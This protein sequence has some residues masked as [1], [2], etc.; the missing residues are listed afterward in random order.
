[1]GTKSVIIPAEEQSAG[2]VVG[3]FYRVEFH[4][5]RRFFSD[6]NYLFSLQRFKNRFRNI[7]DAC[8]HIQQLEKAKAFLLDYTQMRMPLF[9]PN[10]SEL[11]CFQPFPPF[12]SYGVVEG[13]HSTDSND[14]VK[15]RSGFFIH[16]IFDCDPPF[17]PRV[18][19]CRD[20]FKN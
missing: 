11:V 8:D 16:L 20:A 13:S 19:E 2:C 4:S 9:A 12:H 1:M 14:S 18:T 10:V 3:Y 6:S 7:L 17:Y 5:T 15:T